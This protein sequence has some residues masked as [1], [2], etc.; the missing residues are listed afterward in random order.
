MMRQSGKVMLH[1]IAMG[2]LLGPVCVRMSPARALSPDKAFVIP[3]RCVCLQDAQASR[4]STAAREMIGCAAK[5]VF[6]PKYP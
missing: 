6:D 1:H 2:F 3:P 5:E 4:D